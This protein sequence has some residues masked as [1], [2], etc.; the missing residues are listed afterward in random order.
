MADCDETVGDR[1]DDVIR[2]H[3]RSVPASFV[4]D[5]YPGESIVGN[6]A[7]PAVSDDEG[8]SPTTTYA[9]CPNAMPERRINPPAP[10]VGNSIR[11]H[12]V[13]STDIQAIAGLCPLLRP[14]QPPRFVRSHDHVV[15]ICLVD[16]SN[17]GDST[18]V[19]VTPSSDNQTEP[20][21]AAPVVDGFVADHDVTGAAGGD[22]GSHDGPLSRTLEYGQVGDGP[23]LLDGDRQEVPHPY[24]DQAASPKAMSLM[25]TPPISTRSAIRFR[26]RGDITPVGGLASSV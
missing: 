9:P 11:S 15:E 5:L 18:T 6:P 16:Q 26:P 1:D 3:V 12:L 14:S 17:A 25:A 7:V 20:R 21:V 22:R 19:Q 2:V 8:L 10:L 13:P 4:V 24:S 23:D